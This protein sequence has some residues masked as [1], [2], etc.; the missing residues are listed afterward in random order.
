MRAFI[1]IAMIS[2]SL[3][4]TCT[5][6]SNIVQSCTVRDKGFSYSKT[7]DVLDRWSRLLILLNADDLKD[8]DNLPDLISKIKS[9]KTTN[10]EELLG[11]TVDGY[12][13]PLIYITSHGSSAESKISIIRSDAKYPNNRLMLLLVFININTNSITCEIVNQPTHVPIK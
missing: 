7:L 9:K 4:G 12:G 13:D 3:I 5:I 2:L 6:A 1:K 10:D 8:I 11:I